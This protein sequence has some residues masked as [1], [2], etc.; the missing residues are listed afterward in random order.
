MSLI[1][2]AFLILLLAEATYAQNADF[3]AH[4]RL[5]PQPQK[6]EAVAGN[7]ISDHSLRALYLYPGVNRPVMSGIL[8]ELPQIQEIKTG[9]L[10]LKIDTMLRNPSLEGYELLISEGK[11]SITARADAG[12]FYGIQT[13]KQLLEDAR[14]QN[15]EIPAVRITD[16]PEIGYRAVHLDLKHH[17]DA[18]RYYYDMIDRF[19]GIKINAIIIEFEDKLRYRKSPLVGAANAISIEEFAAISKYASERHIE[20]SPLVQGL[21]HASFILKHEEYKHLRDDIASDWV[22]DPLNPETYKLQFSLYEDA[23]AATP[24]GRYLHVGGDEVGSLGKSELSKASGKTPI[25]LQM[26]WLKKVTDFALEHHRI[27]IFWDD[28]VFKLA[29]LYETTYDPAI[30]ATE[31]AARWAKN[32]PALNQVLP[33][34][35][36]KCVYMR[37]NYDDP[38]VPGNINAIDWYKENDLHVMAAT[39]GQ[40]YATIFA[41][42]KSK[43]RP[44]KEFCQLTAEKKMDGI[45]CTIWD[46]ASQHLETITRGVFD[47]ALLSWNYDD[48]P[49]EKAHE[50]YRQRF[51]G[52]ALA[53]NSFDFEDAMEEITTPFWETAFLKEGDR[54]NFH[55]SFTL[56]DLPDS[57]KKGAWSKSNTTKIATAKTVRGKQSE[58]SQQLKQAIAIAPRNRYALTLF[59]VINELETYSSDMMILLDEYDRATRSNEVQVLSKIRLKLAEFPVLRRQLEETYGKTRVMGNPS[60][61]QLDSNFHHHLANGTNNTDWMF[62]YEMGMN[63]KIG[64]WISIHERTR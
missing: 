60:G 39:S 42:T 52:Y 61:Y 44:I 55:A 29:N 54:E 28:M 56:M 3:T 48:V 8:T 16:Y 9:T 5:L 17:I 24:N 19:A 47:F 34:F 33:L 18:T 59:Q 11:V 36:K 15:L 62:L 53:S 14:E 10:S 6:V 50:I 22:F 20:I 57:R 37:W 63:K 41:H 49:I 32:A 40:Y 30:P 43:Y 45:L 2:C 35:P 27:P 64:D 25:E 13:L 31:V 26:Y 1:R 4:F 23:I 58:L 51:Y 7:G 46:D 38:L 21:G 12:L